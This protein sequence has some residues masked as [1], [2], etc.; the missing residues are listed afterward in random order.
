LGGGEVIKIS[1]HKVK[2]LE[3]SNYL[4]NKINFR[5]AYHPALRFA[6]KP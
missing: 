3:L 6:T 2:D 4:E 5:K 1:I